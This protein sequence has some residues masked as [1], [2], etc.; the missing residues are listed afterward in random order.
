MSFRYIFP[1]F[2]SIALMGC[3]NN[4]QTGDYTTKEEP[5]TREQKNIVPIHEIEFVEDIA[6]LDG[7]PFNGIIGIYTSGNVLLSEQTYK[8]GVKEGPW[9]V[10]HPN[11]EL[12]KEGEIRNG[13]EHGRYREWYPN[14]QL[15]YEYQYDAGKKVGKWLSWYEDGTPYTERN[16]VNDQ[17]EGKV[18]VWDEEGLLAKEYDYRSGRQVNAIMHFEN[19]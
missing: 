5:V 11:G 16:F 18:L 10:Y 8:D 15:K 9:S 4:A 6:T 7:A 17:L 2:F 12:Q 19:R 13:L 3:G 14:G 1:I